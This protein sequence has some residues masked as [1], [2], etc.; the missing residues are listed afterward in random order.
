[1]KDIADLQAIGTSDNYRLIQDLQKKVDLY[2]EK[3]E[4][5]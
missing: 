2:L 3:E 4:L 1:M 5:K